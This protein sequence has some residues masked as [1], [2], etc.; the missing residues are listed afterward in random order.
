MKHFAYSCPG[1]S[2][3]SCRM[4]IEP[5]SFKDL[6]SLVNPIVIPIFQ[7]CYCWSETLLKNWWLDATGI[8]I[9]PQVQRNGMINTGKTSFKF[10]GEGDNRQL[11]CVDGQQRCTSTS[12]LL[13]SLR[14]GIL[15]LLRTAPN[16]SHAE[17]TQAMA[18]V[19]EIHRLLF[20]D[21]EAYTSW[22]RNWVSAHSLPSKPAGDRARLKP[23]HSDRRAF[24]ELLTHGLVAYYCWQHMRMPLKISDSTQDS[25][26]G[27]ANR[28]FMAGVRDLTRHSLIDSVT[29]QP[30]VSADLSISIAPA[31]KALRKAFVNVINGM[32][33]MYC[34]ILTPIN[35]PQVFLWMQEKSLLGMGALLQNNNPGVP[36]SA[37]D[38]ARNLLLSEIVLG[39]DWNAEEQERLYHE[40]WVCPLAIPAKMLSDKQGLDGLVTSFIKNLGSGAGDP[41]FSVFTAG[42]QATEVADTAAAA[43]AAADTFL[44][45]ASAKREVGK[46]FDQLGTTFSEKKK[47]K[48][49]TRYVGAAEKT[50]CEMRKGL[51]S[52]PH[53]QQMLGKSVQEDS[54]LDIYVRLHSYCEWVQLKMEKNDQSPAQ[55]G[56]G[57]EVILSARALTSIVKELRDHLSDRLHTT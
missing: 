42:A 12:L 46:G 33:I 43:E 3:S 55:R 10:V 38:L 9:R 52:N 34:E 50:L 19:D 5:V 48:K 18:F 28:I 56:D 32:G 30:G 23:S 26:Q 16:I 54:P 8:H 24:Y 7:R 17:Q 14:D 53:M 1:L 44:S 21:P 4:R 29:K 49:I 47:K 57:G 40:E 51:G 35:F 2:G 22:A 15:Q 39:D 41:D 13:V 36:F 6:F 37:G 45:K 27:L 25:S 20:I 11:V 31:L